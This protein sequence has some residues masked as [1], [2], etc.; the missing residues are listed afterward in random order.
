MSRVD[1]DA[2]LTAAELAER[3]GVRPGTVLGWHRKGRIPARK[4]SQKVLRFDLAEVLAALES[5]DP[6]GRGSAR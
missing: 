3:L 5:A 6:E 1:R 4:L 2:L